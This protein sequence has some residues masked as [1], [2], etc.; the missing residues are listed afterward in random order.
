MRFEEGV[1]SLFYFTLCVNLH[2][3]IDQMTAPG[4]DVEY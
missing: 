1:I 2:F 4:I 3:Q